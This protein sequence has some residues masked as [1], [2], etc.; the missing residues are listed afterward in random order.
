MSS[1]KSSRVCAILLLLSLLTGACG[2]PTATEP[3]ADTE[4]SVVATQAPA[5]T[6]VLEEPVLLVMADR[7]GP[8]T[9]DCVQANNS[10]VDTP[11]INIYNALVQVEPGGFEPK[12]ELAKSWEISDD[13]L[14]YTFYLREGVLFHDGSELT[15]ED[16]KFTV[17]RM[18]ALKKGVYGAFV[19]VTDAEVV[20]DYTIVI[21]LKQVFPSFIVALT[22]LYIFN[23]DLL[24]QHET[25]GDWGEAWLKDHDAG[26]GPY[27]LVSYEPEQQF[28]VEKFPDYFKGWDGPHVDRVVFRGIPEETTRR[29]GLEKG[30]IDWMIISNVETYQALSETPGITVYSDDTLNEFYIALNNN[31][32]YLSD[33]RIRKALALAYDY[34]A[35]VIKHASLSTKSRRG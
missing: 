6:E 35:H 7:G 22:R 24:K 16:V 15:A 2:A 29:L 14:S 32:E 11:C 30:D 9:F 1:F 10:R 13:G 4:V 18:L 25:D 8:P 17:D 3:P 19:R 5:P 21:N 27:M 12:P 28:T 23:S 31:N 20:D 34:E 33:V 26:S